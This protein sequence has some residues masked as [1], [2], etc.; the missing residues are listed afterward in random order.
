MKHKL[1]ILIA[2]LFLFMGLASFADAQESIDAQIARKQQEIN[3]LKKRKLAALEKELAELSR[4]TQNLKQEEPSA[5]M[6]SPGTRSSTNSS[7]SATGRGTG[8]ASD[9]GAGARP[10][11]E[12]RTGNATE[13]LEGIIRT[14]SGAAQDDSAITGCELIRRES[15][16]DPNKYSKRQKAICHMVEAIVERKALSGAPTTEAS[17]TGDVT[18]LETILATKLAESPGTSQLTE[19]PGIFDKA[20]TTF[21]LGAENAR[22]DKQA[23]SDSKSSGTTSLAVKGGVPAFLAW[24]VESGG[25]ESEKDGNTL[26]FRINPVGF[27]DSLSRWG[28]ANGL[29]RPSQTG[30]LDNLFRQDDGLVKILR[31]TSVGFSFDVSRG[32]DTPLFT[33]DKQQLSAVSV[34]YQ[35]LNERDPLHP[36]YREDWKQYREKH[37]QKFSDVT[38]KNVEVLFTI[39]PKTAKFKNTDLA[40]WLDDLNT[41]LRA[42]PTNDLRSDYNPLRD[43][44]PASNR[45]AEE[46]LRAILEEKIDKLPLDKIKNDTALVSALSDDVNASI[47][48]KNQFDLVMKKIANGQVITFEYTNYREV[49][50]PDLSNFRAIISK[51]F[52]DGADLTFNGSLTM[53]NKKPV[54]VDP[55]AK[56]QRIRDFDFTL[57]A[58]IPFSSFIKRA[59]EDLAAPGNDVRT[60]ILGIPVFTFAG[61]YQRLQSDAVMPDGAVKTG[62][63]G[64]LA[65]GQLKLT[66]PINIAGFNMKLPFSVTFANRTDLIKEKEVRGNF[67]FTLD[68]DPFFSKLKSALTGGILGQ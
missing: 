11:V 60:P 1:L 24:A 49:N 37:L 35:F 42:V 21:L 61:K 28:N 13:T 44:I 26:T 62:T 20:V 43:R 22:L 27:A 58:D 59:E 4:E 18:D 25:A 29:I 2:V 68:I 8:A 65:F 66:I 6:P 10:A 47:E 51:G 33:G 67:G 3:E 46:E 50:A 36:K 14:V 54:S 57:Q 40:A 15:K 41:A 9:S 56:I 55:T 64:D 12:R 7:I 45:K 52:W 53:F 5:N 19:Q 30:G 39:D 48:L 63:R 34:R 32:T 16:T 31:N 38:A 17:I 23:G